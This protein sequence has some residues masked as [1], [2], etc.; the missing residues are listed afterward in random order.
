[1]IPSELEQH[2]SGDAHDSGDAQGSDRFS[3][4][5]DMRT[6]L[7]AFEARAGER[8]FERVSEN[9]R[10]RQRPSSTRETNPALIDVR[11][12][13]ADD[14]RW[15][16]GCAGLVMSAIPPPADPERPISIEAT[17]AEACRLLEN[18]GLFAAFLAP[19]TA[20]PWTRPGDELLEHFGREGLRPWG[21]ILW[22]RPK[23][24]VP[25][26]E[27][28]PVWRSPYHLAMRLPPV[29]II[30][31][32]LDAFAREGASKPVDQRDYTDRYFPG[33]KKWHRDF[34]VAWWPMQDTSSDEVMTGEAVARLIAQR[35][36]ARET[37][38]CLSGELDAAIAAIQMGRRC[39]LVVDNDHKLEVANRRLKA[40]LRQRAEAASS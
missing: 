25:L 16:E 31:A 18:N 23:A 33:P 17:V 3:L 34:N 11:V 7:G 13:G 15:P 21:E 19:S 39:R 27:A 40:E 5:E 26:A 12:A 6:V 36:M 1:M 24:S 20:P 32:T 9:R 4:H 37:M 30:L 10:L 28:E 29:R 8:K 22:L 2:G 38:V 14:T 35:G